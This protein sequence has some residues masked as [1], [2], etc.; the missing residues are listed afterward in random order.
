[1][2]CLPELLVGV[3]PAA[4]PGG[5]SSRAGHSRCHRQWFSRTAAVFVPMSPR[6]HTVSASAE[7]RTSA[8]ATSARTSSVGSSGAAPLA[9]MPRA[10]AVRREQAVRWDE[11][12]P[13]A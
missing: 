1:V 7:R 4:L 12:R 8:S 10:T 6:S 13:N 9:V 2:A 3:V 11:R 5:G